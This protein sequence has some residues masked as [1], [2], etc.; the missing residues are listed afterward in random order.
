MNKKK[1]L[2]CFSILGMFSTLPIYSV[3]ANEAVIKIEKP[4]IIRESDSSGEL[5]SVI[6]GQEDKMN[7]LIHS[8]GN[9]NGQTNNSGSSSSSGNSNYGA[10]DKYNFMTPDDILG[11]Q[12]VT[13]ESFGNTIVSRL[14][15]VVSLFQKFAKPF[16]IIMFI[17]SALLVLVSL[18]F[19][20]N[21]VKTGF[22]GMMLSV[23]A[24]V[25]VMY[26]PDIVLFFTQWLS[27]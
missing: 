16:T 24:Y 23:L 19:G 11:N 8:N 15:D 21:K 10:S 27:V 6:K 3:Y 14:L 18:V 26:A 9:A 17:L 13:I 4:E 2:L 7:S 20:T 5:D 1:V 25:G 22:L 12:D